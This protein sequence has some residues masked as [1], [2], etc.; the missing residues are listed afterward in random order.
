MIVQGAY[1]GTGRASVDA[2]IGEA[3]RPC[4]STTRSGLYEHETLR[5][6]SVSLANTARVETMR[7]VTGRKDAGA[8]IFAASSSVTGDDASDVDHKGTW[9]VAQLCNEY[10]TTCRIVV[11][12]VG[13][14][15]TNSAVYQFFSI[16]G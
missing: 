2:V 4:I 12:R 5:I 10:K 16:V 1:G 9:N 6:L 15:G 3:R 11:S 7:S 13:V 8:V 14:T